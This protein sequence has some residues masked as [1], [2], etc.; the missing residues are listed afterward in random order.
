DPEGVLAPFVGGPDRA[1]PRGGRV[2]A[3]RLTTAGEDEGRQ[4]VA[5]RGRWAVHPYGVRAHHEARPRGVRVGQVF[6][7]VQ[8]VRVVH[9]LQGASGAVGPRQG[10]ATPHQVA[11]TVRGVVRAVWCS[12]TDNDDGTEGGRD[13]LADEGTTAGHR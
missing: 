2:D 11:R 8:R 10:W 9:W 5:D 3:G 4:A 12:A 6:H 1:L 7:R 13:G